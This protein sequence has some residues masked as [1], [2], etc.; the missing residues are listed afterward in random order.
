MRV[1]NQFL[2]WLVAIVLSLFSGCSSMLYYPTQQRYFEPERLGLKVEDLWIPSA[3]GERLHGWYF[4]AE[5]E[6]NPK[7][8]V[9]F[10]HG[11]AEN[12]TSH[13]ASL[14]WLPSHGF[15]YFIFDYRGYGQSSGKATPENTV[16]DGMQV[17][18][19]MR[20]R[21]PKGVPLV[22]FGQSL[23]G[24]VALRALIE[25]KHEISV[26]LVVVDS[27]FGSYR[28]AARRM[29]S[30]NWLTWIFQ[31]LGLLLMSDAWAPG[32][33]VS[34][35]APTPLV[36]MHGDEDRVIDYRLGEKLF[37]DAG[38]PKEFWK[39]EGGAH[40]DGFWRHGETYRLRF[41]RKMEEILKRR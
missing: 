10:F 6:K 31:P 32:K 24:A 20:S 11:N 35:L 28:S 39:V 17:M 2:A 7:A 1:K 12:L 8:L 15:D 41:L 34:E 40:T 9:V 38:E 27:S 25:L 3:D 30:K 23:G 26:A 37:E 19:A 22:V 5:T 16:M 29:L 21:V 13:F 36:V 18:R 33:R 4:R 14:A